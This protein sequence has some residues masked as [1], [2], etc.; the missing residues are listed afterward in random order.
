MSLRLNTGTEEFP[1]EPGDEL[2]PPRE[3]VITE[4]IAAV[5]L[6]VLSKQQREWEQVALGTNNPPIAP[7]ARIA[8]ESGVMERRIYGILNGETLFTDLDITDRLLMAAGITMAMEMPESAFITTQDAN[9]LTIE[10]SAL[11]K[12]IARARGDYVPP[13]GSKAMRHWPG[14]YR[15]RLFQEQKRAA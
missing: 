7:L 12:N 8:A 4:D 1:L 15:R 14:P 9:E 11:M 2:T 10:H 13:S 5:L 6:P 3:V